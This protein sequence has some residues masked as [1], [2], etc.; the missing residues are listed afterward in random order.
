MGKSQSPSVKKK[1]I[2]T[3]NMTVW[4][5]RSVGAKKTTKCDEKD[6]YCMSLTIYNAL[7]CIKVH[8]LWMYAEGEAHPRSDSKQG[9][10]GLGAEGTNH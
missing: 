4:R 2:S 10:V 1:C 8:Q 6:G 5:R 7:F 3:P 9:T